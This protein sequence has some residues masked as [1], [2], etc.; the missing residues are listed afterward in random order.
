MSETIN[1]EDLIVLAYAPSNN[2]KSVI[3]SVHVEK[4]S[5]FQE[6]GFSVD[7]ERNV[8]TYKAHSHSTHINIGKSRYFGPTRQYGVIGVYNS[9]DIKHLSTMANDAG[10]IIKMSAA[11]YDF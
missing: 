8:W 4:L 3:K 11:Q 1:L 5:D 9:K 10:H 2:F 7:L 6:E